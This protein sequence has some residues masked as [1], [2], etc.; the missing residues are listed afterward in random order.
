M[1]RNC[2][3]CE[4]L[5]TDQNNGGVVK[6]RK[7]NG[8]CLSVT[9]NAGD[10]ERMKTG[11]VSER[12][13][14]SCNFNISKQQSA[15]YVGPERLAYSLDDYIPLCQSHSPAWTLA[16][17][18]L[19]TLAGIDIRFFYNPM[20]RI[21]SINKNKITDLERFLNEI[22]L[23]LPGL[24]YLSLLGNPAC[25]DQLS[26]SDHDEQDYRRYRSYVVHRI[27]TLRFLDSTAIVAMNGRRH[28][29]R[30]HYY[31]LIR[32]NSD[33]FIEKQRSA[34][35]RE[36]DYR[37]QSSDGGSAGGATAG[38]NGSVSSTGG[39]RQLTPL[40][41]FDE[42]NAPKGGFGRLRHRYTGK[43]SEGNRFIRNHEL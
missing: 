22:S 13:D 27:P 1:N 9:N 41:S 31:R 38:P 34:A 23:K 15:T 7:E 21:L 36:E 26:S 40:P 5:A 6:A 2:N 33:S 18:C 42:N 17:T 12:I 30:G 4:N 43:H 16:S 37:Q 39:K 3:R 20:M 29:Q 11:T 28:K 32:L 8:T 10:S 35:L 14:E 24:T 25:P 19:Q